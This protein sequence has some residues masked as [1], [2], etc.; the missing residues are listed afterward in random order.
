MMKKTLLSWLAI[1]VMQVNAQGWQKPVI[2]ASKYQPLTAETTFYLYN[3]GS[4][5]FA[6][7]GNEYHTH[8]SVAE[9]G[10]KFKVHQYVLSEASGWDGVTYTI[11]DSVVTQGAWKEV[12]FEN[13]PHIFVDRYNQ[14]NYYFNF[15]EFGGNE[16]GIYAA[17][18]NPDYK[19]VVYRGEEGNA[20]VGHNTEYLPYRDKEEEG[21]GVQLD[22]PTKF[23]EG[24]FLYRWAF[25]SEQDYTDYQLRLHTYRQAV[26]LGKLIEQAKTEGVDASEALNVYT[27]TSAT[28][29][30]LTDAL[31]TLKGKMASCGSMENPRDVTDSYLQNA[32]F[33]ESFK[34]WTS[35]M[36]ARNNQLQTNSTIGAEASVEGAF[37]G[38]FWENWSS[39]AFKGRMYAMVSDLPNGVYRF[40][41]S[42]FANNAEKAYV[43][44]N[45]ART[46]VTNKTGDRYTVLVFVNNGVM[47][48]GLELR[49]V[50]NNWVGIDNAQLLYY[51]QSDEALMFW[52]EDVDDK[53][54]LSVVHE[55]ALDDELAVQRNAVQNADGY[56]EKVKAI[57]DYKIVVD[58]IEW[59]KKVYTLY[60]E[61]CEKANDVAK[62]SNLEAARNLLDYMGE[63]EAVYYDGATATSDMELH[64]E[65]IRQ[66]MQVLEESKALRNEYN[67]AFLQLE[68]ALGFYAE[69]ASYEAL[70]FALALYVETEAHIG[71]DDLTDEQIR[72]QITV[73]TDAIQA[74]RI[75]IGYE[76]ASDEQP[77]DMTMAIA[78]PTFMNDTND[79][80][81][82]SKPGRAQKVGAA[83]F[84]NC[85]FDMYQ[86]LKNLPNGTYKL[87]V[88]GFYRAGWPDVEVL[89]A[90]RKGE[91]TLNSFFYA[92]SDDTEVST[93]LKS[94]WEESYPVAVGVGDEKLVE[95]VFTPNNM[96]AA[97]GYFDEGRF[98]NVLFIKVEN[99]ELRLG[100]RKALQV[101]A[102]WTMFDNFTLTYY[103]TNSKMD[104]TVIDSPSVS[105]N[106]TPVAYYTLDGVKHNVRQRGVNILRYADGTYRM[107][108]Y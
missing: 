48:C 45:D 56:D 9:S 63:Y 16:Y 35:T 68:E 66:L 62:L 61:T 3:T 57:T 41:L 32:N 65:H 52:F 100:L 50:K 21:T 33:E 29:E 98:E 60:L 54:D 86:D 72:W 88:Q 19:H 4:Q 94:V 20:Y 36:G 78:N 58:K 103:G 84:W 97:V 85:N 96:V 47:E 14:N 83:E 51:G 34:G 7:Q 99:G 70:E 31:R 108:K 27:N 81:S 42:A 55:F 90:W 26:C 44:A 40:N 69:V 101:V 77:F 5:L 91:S 8:L 30:Q 64:I 15:E 105:G 76:D 25:I 80:W 46:A 39:S 6:T 49:E 53:Q 73:I 67:A 38:R 13:F 17:D 93:M 12:F 106:H 102:D 92:Q 18:C 82:G 59:S 71:A 10:L 43:F 37:N 74:L 107:L 2:D 89:Q 87:T 104:P 28:L 95:D 75:P 11:S 79:G 22:F 23:E 24:S 1:S